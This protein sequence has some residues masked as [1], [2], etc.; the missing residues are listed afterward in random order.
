MKPNPKCHTCGKPPAPHLYATCLECDRK[1]HERVAQILIKSRGGKR[2]N[3]GRK[4]TGP[5]RAKISLTVSHEAAENIR[6]AAKRDGSSV[7]S[8]AD[9]LFLLDL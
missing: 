2:P 7:S 3:A 8:I 1:T 4:P 9:K 6:R 5:T